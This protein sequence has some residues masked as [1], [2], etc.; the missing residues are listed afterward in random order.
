[1]IAA[2]FTLVKEEKQSQEWK[3]LCP[4][5]DITLIKASTTAFIPISSLAVSSPLRLLHKSPEPVFGGTNIL[6]LPNPVACA[7]LQ[8]P[9]DF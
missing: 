5:N 1:M 2:L 3:N 9:L 4:R 6:L 7:S 8:I